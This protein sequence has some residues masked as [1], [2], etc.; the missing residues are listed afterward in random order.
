MRASRC[1]VVWL[2]MKTPTMRNKEYE[3]FENPLKVANLGMSFVDFER[4][5]AL[6]NTLKPSSFSGSGSPKVTAMALGMFT[7]ANF[8]CV[9]S[10]SQSWAANLKTGVEDAGRV[11]EVVAARND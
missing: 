7:W 9:P 1:S 3:Y 2:A 5:R 10:S 11:A 6:T 4:K 8:R